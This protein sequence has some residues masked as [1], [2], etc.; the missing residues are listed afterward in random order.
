VLVMDR[1]CRAGQVV[2]RIDLQIERQRDVVAAQPEPG[3]VEQVKD[4][5]LAAP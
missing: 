2:D 5:L 3:I 1:T 4:V